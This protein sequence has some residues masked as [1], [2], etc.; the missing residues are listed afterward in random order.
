MGDNNDIVL[1]TPSGN[2]P[3]SYALTGTLPL[4]LSYTAGTNTISGT[5]TTVTV[6]PAVLTLTATDADGDTGTQTVTITV[7]A[8]APGSPGNLTATPGGLQVIPQVALAWG[9]PTTGG[10]TSSYEVRYRRNSGTSG[11]PIWDSWTA[12]VDVGNV[13]AHT[14]GTTVGTRLRSDTEYEFAV[15]AR[16]AAGASAAVTAQATT[17]DVKPGQPTN[18]AVTTPGTPG[19][20]Q[21]TVTW[22]APT[23]SPCPV[24]AYHVR[25]RQTADADVLAS[26]H[27]AGSHVG[28]SSTTTSVTVQVGSTYGYWDSSGNPVDD[29]GDGDI[30]ASDTQAETETTLPDGTPFTV[31]V[32]SSSTGCDTSS[33]NAEATVTTDEAD[34]GLSFPSPKTRSYMWFLDEA[35]DE[36]LP[37]PGG[38]DPVTFVLT[39]NLPAGLTYNTATNRISGPPTD[40][41]VGTATVT[42]TATDVD[43]DTD[44]L[45]VNI[46][47]KAS[48]TPKNLAATPS[49]DVNGHPQMSLAWDAPTIGRTPTYYEVRHRFSWAPDAN[50]VPWGP[51]S[52][53]V[54]V[55]A[56]TTYAV[57]G[58]A[59]NGFYGFEVRAG[60]TVGVSDSVAV[61]DRAPIVKPDP[62]ANVAVTTPGTPGSRGFTVTW[63]APTN[64][65][66]AINTYQLRYYTPPANRDVISGWRI[67]GSHL[68]L[69]STTTSF[70]V[71]LNSTYG[72]FT[73]TGQY[74]DVNG[75]LV[76]DGSDVLLE[77]AA[78]LPYDTEFAMEIF[79]FSNICN[80]WSDGISVPNVTTDEEDT[81]PSFAADDF[82]VAL[83]AGRPIDRSLPTAS[84]G[85][86]PVTYTLAATPALPSW[87]TFNAAGAGGPKLE[88]TQAPASPVAE[89]TY[90][91]TAT[92]SNG[93]SD[94]IELK[95]SVVADTVPSF[96]SSTE[97][98]TWTQGV[99]KTEALPDPGGNTPVSY[100]LAGTLP[101]GL[102]YDDQTNEISG[103]A[104]TLT[105]TP[106]VLTLS[107]T[108]VD[109]DS[110]PSTVSISIS[111]VPQLPGAPENLTATPGGL[112]M[113]PQVT[114]NWD[115]PTTG[116]APQQYEIRSCRNIG[117]TDSPVWDTCT[118]FDI[119]PAEVTTY[120][121]GTT[122][123]LLLYS[124]TEY[125]FQVM[126]VNVTGAS[127]LVSVRATTPDVRPGQPTNVAVSTPGTA[128]SKQFTVTW[129]APTTSPCPVS[130]YKV[131]HRQTADPDV[132]ASY[133]AAE[134]HEGFSSTT[135]SA[136]VQDGSTY[137]YWDSAG[138]PVDLNGD[139]RF[140]DS[141]TANET[142]TTLPDATPFT[143]R[144]FAYSDGC[145][146]SSP[147]VEVTVTTDPSS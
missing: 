81:S 140:N 127:P 104:T 135:T 16:N 34:T 146:S 59:S 23:S 80:S 97:S 36:Q 76:I 118:F 90:T 43:G 115:A 35:R 61:Q 139:G 60:N 24:N 120:T 12:W 56:V 105:M 122:S 33:P 71:Q 28:F 106:A 112:Q 5:A 128:G 11:A 134:S 41:G 58:L 100:T 142:A 3:I 94:S 39:G 131:H 138:E 121:F 7:V 22:S 136:T 113:L 147:Y 18:V 75:D 137:G 68:H 88:G 38:N 55:G 85:N 67:A 79:S 109:G 124:D 144:V 92:D 42:I 62:P 99:D 27:A 83:S 82:T 74:L 69:D 47:V 98:Y 72:A 14:V 132:L 20:K 145:K 48:D 65:V 30:D 116:G 101:D 40:A 95:V 17:A 29:N 126:A 114:L 96:P 50:P 26:Y 49:T 2:A 86:D 4:A 102:T 66:C 52:N 73:S 9:A 21:F 70:T 130:A 51:W 31:R 13:T 64:S 77:T 91:M 8:A 54:D 119:V 110:A 46:T 108:D 133:H 44:T 37:D 141:D 89:E 25:Y 129:A 78:T 125:R 107:A 143:I 53:W 103:T 93:D 6:A 19:S 87:L 1:D 15:R 57:T 45:T 63:D 10:T 117:T 111:V 123:P 84:E 32:S